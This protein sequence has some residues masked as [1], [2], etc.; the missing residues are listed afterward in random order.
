MNNF[1]IRD[2]SQNSPNQKPKTLA[3]IL[4]GYGADG[5]NLVDI[6]D[7]LQ[8]S[9]EL[10]IFIIPDAPFGY[11]YSPNMGRQ[12]FSLMDRDESVLVKG[13]EVAHKILL[14][15][16]D[17]NLEKYGLGYENLVLIGFSQGAMMSMFTGLQL[18]KQCKAIVSLSGTIVSA[19]NTISNCKTKPPVC[20]IHGENDDVVP[21]PL[22]KFTAKTLK[23]IGVNVKIHE[24][25]NL[26]H[27]IDMRCLK[28]AADFLKSI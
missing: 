25:A 23:Q 7:V 11:E 21:L 19:E 4:H 26:A 12:W 15:F 9:L 8:G 24:I 2:F 28:I 18:P 5:E 1:H 20:I 22:G 13:A 6:A 16:I 27:G 14:N 10:P 17:E 3:L